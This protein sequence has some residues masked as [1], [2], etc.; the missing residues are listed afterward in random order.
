MPG[1]TLHFVVAERALETWRSSPG[2][3]PFDVADAAA[4]NAF[5]HGAVGPDLG[6]FPGGHRILSDLAHC[7]RTG[8]LARTLVKS[9]E[10]PTERAFAWGW[11]THV[12]ADREIHPLIGRGVG[13]LLTGCRHTFI[14]GS[15]H[16]QAHLRVEMGVDAWFAREHPAVLAVR[17]RPAF[18]KSSIGFLT[19]AYARVYGVDIPGSL[20]L[21]S[22]RTAG[23]RV[24]QA[25][26]SV[27]LV[28]ALMRASRS[29]WLARLPRALRSLYNSGTLRHV[30]LA[31]LNP[32]APAGWLRDGIMRAVGRLAGLFARELKSE[33]RDLGDYHLD[34][35]RPLEL[36]AGHPATRRSLRALHE[37]TTRGA[38]ERAQK[39]CSRFSFRA[40]ARLRR[41]VDVS[42][43]AAL[44]AARVWP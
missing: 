12:L 4:L 39:P 1:V 19:S 33:A 36:E 24:G 31:Y 3:A 38:S 17:L 35:G 18:D 9:A 13:S 23:R 30:F 43:A 34:T 22:H 25:L 28:G 20:F 27:G 21:G 10:T 8:E 40:S 7:V 11:L 2:G 41:S 32:V 6:Y 14:D 26:A 16:P 42:T 5:Y 29:T 44:A 37:M 15:S